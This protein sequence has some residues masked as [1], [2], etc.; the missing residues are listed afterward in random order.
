MKACSGCLS[1]N[2]ANKDAQKKDWRRHKDICKVL[3][4]LVRQRP[5]HHPLSEK[6]ELSG[7]IQAILQQALNRE[8]TQ[9]ESDMLI[10]PRL[11]MVC[12]GG[13]QTEL[14]NCP[15]C[16][17]VSY[18]SQSHQAEDQEEH[19][20][21][22][23]LLRV[24]LEDH[25]MEMIMGCHLTDPSWTL[26][27]N[28][29]GRQLGRGFQPRA[30]T[31]VSATPGLPSKIEQVFEGD[32]RTY[33]SFS[34]SSQDCDSAAVFHSEVRYLTFKY[35]C[36]LS[37][38]H[39]LETA[40]MPNGP[41]R[42]Y[43]SLTLH[44]VGARSAESSE[45]MRWEILA[46]HLPLLQ[47]LTIVL[48]GPEL[49]DDCR[50]L[51]RQNVNAFILITRRKWN[52]LHRLNR[53]LFIPVTFIC[54]H[55]GLEILSWPYP[56]SDFCYTTGH[57]RTLRPDLTIR[58]CFFKATYHDFVNSKAAKKAKVAWPDAISALNCGFIFYQSWDASIPSMLRSPGVPLIFT[59]Y[60][61]QDCQLNLDKV[62]DLVEPEL[63]VTLE[64]QENPFCSS[65]PARIPTGFAF[66]KFKRRN[67]V[68][69]NDFICCVKWN[70]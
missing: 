43:T 32:L 29:K 42:D 35:T 56:I 55:P 51:K 39:A 50:Y 20:K 2:Y 1:V 12:L 27:S 24:C 11:C 41:I 63:E 33:L 68:M 23:E 5:G 69:S 8:L 21:S 57:L 58:Y 67:V 45:V 3:Q 17:C 48:I 14:F 4:P 44:V 70:Q 60:Y 25:Q 52:I 28:S 62:D 22:C 59:E 7:Q 31:M 16:H 30:M 54:N 18:C 65:L 47:N 37:T 36:Q 26:G 46:A 10:Y 34:V 64:P 66:R 38:L 6:P 19:A 13:R 61:L 15:I 49:R 53:L 9:F 40:G